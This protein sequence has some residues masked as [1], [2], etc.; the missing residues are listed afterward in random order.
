MCKLEYMRVW[1]FVRNIFS[2][3][4]TAVETIYSRRTNVLY[5][6]R[7]HFL[8]DINSPYESM[9]FVPKCRIVIYLRIISFLFYTLDVIYLSIFY[10]SE[11][12]S[13]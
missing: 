11:C 2:V 9:Y 1:Q 3:T 8:K 10:Q 5:F 6:L 13:D 4:V 12:E 7:T